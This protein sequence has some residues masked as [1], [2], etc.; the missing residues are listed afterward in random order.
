M[1]KTVEVHQNWEKNYNKSH[2]ILKFTVPVPPEGGY[3][4][5]FSLRC[6]LSCMQMLTNTKQAEL[7]AC[8]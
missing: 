8:N 3:G 7:E 2:G 4:A 1:K 5:N 6:I